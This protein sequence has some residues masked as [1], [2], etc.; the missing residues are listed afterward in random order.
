MGD[1]KYVRLND[2]KLLLWLRAKMNQI[3]DLFELNTKATQ[4][5]LALIRAQAEGYMASKHDSLSHGT[6][7]HSSTAR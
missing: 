5:G 4:L 1:D 7:P 6:Y 3:C 2:N